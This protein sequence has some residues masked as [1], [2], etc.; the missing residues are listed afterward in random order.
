MK[1][2]LVAHLEKP[3]KSGARDNVGAAALSGCRGHASVTVRKVVIPSQPAQPG[4]TAR[5]RVAV[6]S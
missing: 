4:G 6:T 2:K 3:T 1:L 5:S